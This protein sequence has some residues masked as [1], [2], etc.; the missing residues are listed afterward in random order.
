M[1][2][3]DYLVIGH[4]CQDL[5][6]SGPRLGGTATFSALTAQALGQRVGVLTSAPDSCASLFGPLDGLALIRIPSEHPTTFEN[7]YTA[8][9]RTQTL[10]ERATPLEPEHLPRAWSSIA[11]IHLAPVADEVA[12]EFVDRFPGAFIGATPQGWMRTWDSEGRVRYRPWESAARVLSGAQ[13]VILSLEDVRGDEAVTRRYADQVGCLVVT[14][15]PQGCTLYTQ[16]RPRDIPAPQVT[17]RDTTGAGDIFAAVFFVHLKASGD[18][19]AAA[20]LATR[21]ASDSV[22]RVGLA[23][24]PDAASIRAALAAL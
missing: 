18:P 16:G 6:P 15:G 9:G 13:A 3:I 2:P 21:L 12:P 22:T 8:T 10:W 20:R 7:V 1:Q 23:S 24:I 14:R 17:V 19:F 4:V 11:I 5:T